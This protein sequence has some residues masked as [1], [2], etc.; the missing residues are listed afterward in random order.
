MLGNVRSKAVASLLAGVAAAFMLVGFGQAT[1][2]AAVADDTHWAVVDAASTE[3][4]AA[5]PL[6]DTHW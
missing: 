5:V 4:A 6:A 3:D 1:A 2:T